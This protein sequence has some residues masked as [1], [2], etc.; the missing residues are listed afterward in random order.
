MTK[1]RIPELRNGEGD[2]YLHEG[3]GYAFSNSERPDARTNTIGKGAMRT[4]KAAEQVV[5]M[6][7]DDTEERAATVPRMNANDPGLMV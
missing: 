6:F 5:R 4:R 3:V 7:G 2:D 1:N